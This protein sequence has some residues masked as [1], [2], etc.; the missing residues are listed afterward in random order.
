MKS[1]N[2][3][4][5]DNSES[6]VVLKKDQSLISFYREQRKTIEKSR[7]SE[8]SVNWTNSK[9]RSRIFQVHEDHS[10]KDLSRDAIKIPSFSRMENKN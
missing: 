9:N 2:N 10:S 5:Q 1:L 7:V 3:P 6:K 8:N 4:D